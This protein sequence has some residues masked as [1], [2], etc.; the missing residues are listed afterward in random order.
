MSMYDVGVLF[1]TQKVYAICKEVKPNEYIESFQIK[2]TCPDF[3]VL[4]S[5][6]KL[7]RTKQRTS[8]MVLWYYGRGVDMDIKQLVCES[9]H[10]I[11]E[12]YDKQITVADIS[13]QAHLSPSYF[14]TVFRV[15][16]GY[17]VKNYLNRY[18]LYRATLQLVEGDKRIIEIAFESGFLSQQ[19]FTKS[20]S[21]A[22]GIAP[23]KFRLL[24]PVVKQFPPENIFKE[25]AMELK[26]CF[27]NVRFMHK[28]AFFVAGLEVDINYNS[29]N[30][31]EPIGGLWETWNTGE[32]LKSIPDIVGD[33]PYSYGMT[34]GETAEGTAKYFV[35][36]EVSTLANLPVG[37]VGRRFDES[38]YA[39]FKMR[40]EDEH[41]KFWREFYTKWLPQSGYT[42]KEEQ[43]REDRPNFTKY[44]DI[45]YYN[46]DFADGIIYIYAPVVKK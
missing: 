34:H 7:F 40:F 43:V 14:S 23:A 5:D 19:S 22:F 6:K 24:K 42:M 35:G 11:H 3:D 25:D 44:A 37:L 21:Q 33:E 29:E 2:N 9:T 17:T 45:E 30:G 27:N 26:D 36:V 15:L 32:L 13:A 18:R 4:S 1:I 46:K 20:F 16:T 10:F 41:P 28:N 31:T 38:D 39:V 8:T 12:N